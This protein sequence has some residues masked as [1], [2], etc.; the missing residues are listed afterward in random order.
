M[1]KTGY[2]RNESVVILLSIRS[3]CCQSPGNH[4]DPF[5]K[6][7]VV[8]RQVFDGLNFF[9]FC[10]LGIDVHGRLNVCM[11]HNGLDCFNVRLYLTKPGTERMPQMMA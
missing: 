2:I 1:S 3:K 11:T 7:T 6:Y 10:R 8:R 4:K 9:I 5:L